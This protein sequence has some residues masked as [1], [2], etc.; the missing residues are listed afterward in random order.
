MVVTCTFSYCAEIVFP[1][2]IYFYKTEILGRLFH[3]STCFIIYR[4][5]NILRK[6]LH[7]YMKYGVIRLS[8]PINFIASVKLVN[9]R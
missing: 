8:S 1:R 7:S 5:A 3:L 4:L 9:E 6:I 2:V